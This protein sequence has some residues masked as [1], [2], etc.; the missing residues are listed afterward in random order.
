MVGIVG[1]FGPLKRLF[2]RS[3][4]TPVPF[5]KKSSSRIRSCFAHILSYWNWPD[6]YDDLTKDPIF[7]GS[8]TSLSGNG[9]YI[10]NKGDIVLHVDNPPAIILPPGSGGG[11]VTSG[12]F[13]DYQV[14]LGPGSL[15]LPGNKTD[16]RE[17]PLDYNPRCLKRDLTTEVIR[18]FANYSSVAHLISKNDHIWN[19]QTEMQGPQGSTS[20]GVHGGGHYAIG[21]DPG[22][23]FM[24]SPGDPAFYLH[25]SMID[26][27]W[28][29]WQN[30]DPENRETAISGTNTL[31]NN[32]PSENTTLDTLVDLGYAWGKPVPMRDIMSTVKG[33]LCYVYL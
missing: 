5:R 25:H 21:G 7:D 4:A 24:V 29:I 8:D 16:S 11:C 15:S 14:N 30:Q 31:H 6:S 20:L 28:W 18:M 17:N 12:P 33:S 26:R 9:E 13:K 1:T 3:V 10:P 19:F 2:E 23:D 27:V 32:P 22:R